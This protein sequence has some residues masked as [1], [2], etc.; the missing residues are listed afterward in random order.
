M[1]HSGG[2][3]SHGGGSHGGS[4][5]SHGS[6]SYR[7]SHYFHGARRFRKRYHDGREEYFY[8]RSK[9]V[10]T[11]ISGLV[12]MLIFGSVFTV[13]MGIGIGSEIPK[14]LN[15]EYRTPS[16]RIYD[17]IDVIE[18]DSELEDVLEEFNDLTG[19]CPVVYT[20][21]V[22]DYNREY[23]D[24]ESFA[25]YQYLDMFD[26]EQHYLVVYAIPEYQVEDYRNGRMD[27]PDYEVEVVM[28][29][30]TDNIITDNMKDRFKNDVYESLG[31]GDR[32]EEAFES[33]FK[34]MTDSA[35][36]RLNGNGNLKVFI[37]VIFVGLI[38]LI[39]VIAMIVNM[40]KEKEF[41]YEEV[42]LT[43]EDLKSAPTI[44][45][46]NPYAG[47]PG[48]N[49]NPAMGTAFKAIMTVMMIP[50][51]CIGIGLITGGVTEMTSGDVFGT[52]KLVF[53]I[54]WTSIIL[55]MLVSVFRALR[56]TEKKD[57]VMT[58]DYPKADMP[59]AEYPQADYPEASDPEIRKRPFW[60]PKSDYDDDDDDLR[61]KGYE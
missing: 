42:D 11:G 57:P 17:N 8:S 13:L 45:M 23:V 25:Y 50:F 6:S 14:R 43:E 47:M 28:G 31:D 4:H 51:V 52:V 10:K 24:L 39:P 56:N 35:D 30:E 48:R 61:R 19:I 40:K 15:E 53:G 21:T 41:E 59:H 27:I 7:S 5:G 18:D 49:Y 26:D 46:A 33:A 36:K 1:P 20:M 55:I 38:L 2:G 34:S 37:P 9:P 32:P 29:D 54:V 22:Q 12:F 58:A 16:S 60:S 44:D 3:G